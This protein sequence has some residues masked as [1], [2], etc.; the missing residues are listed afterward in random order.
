[1]HTA[2]FGPPAGTREAPLCIAS[3]VC[4]KEAAA[5]T[6]L[7]SEADKDPALVAQRYEQ[8]ESCTS[9]WAREA[10]AEQA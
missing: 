8:M 9:R 2:H 6:A 10:S 5:F 7:K 1:M 4:P 3:Q